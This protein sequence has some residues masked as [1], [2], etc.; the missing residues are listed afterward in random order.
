VVDPENPK[1]LQHWVWIRFAANTVV[2]S[3][4]WRLM[5]T[6]RLFHQVMPQTSQKSVAFEPSWQWNAMVSTQSNDDMQSPNWDD[7]EIQQQDLLARRGSEAIRMP[8]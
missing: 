4:P 7:H 8:G 2:H 1:V 5:S 3:T 6:P